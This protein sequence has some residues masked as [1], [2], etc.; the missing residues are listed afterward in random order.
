MI[1][2]QKIPIRIYLA[3]DYRYHHLSA[4]MFVIEMKQFEESIDGEKETRLPERKV[5][6]WRRNRMTWNIN[7]K[8][9]L[10]H[11]TWSTEFSPF[12]DKKVTAST[13]EVD[14]HWLSQKMPGL[15]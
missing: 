1:G 10:I 14:S 9:R 13:D 12:L 8:A 11:D 2:L 4:V 3:R 5:A 6:A 7:L 15:S